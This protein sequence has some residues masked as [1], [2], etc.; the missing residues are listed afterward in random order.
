MN[1]LHRILTT[2][3]LAVCFIAAMA[4]QVSVT[5][6]PKRTVL[7]PQVM[8][9]ISNPGQYFNI[10]VQNPENEAQAIFFG[11]ELRQL[12]PTNAINIVI[13]ALTLPKQGIVIPAMQTRMLDAVQMR[14][15][16]QH[17]R[18]SDIKMPQGLFD[19]VANGSF[20]MLE[21]GTY[22]IVLNAYKWDPTLSSPVLLSN[23]TLSRCTFTICY[24]ASAPK[25]VS[26]VA[27]NDYE[28][29]NIATLSQQ[30]PM[31]QWTSPV[32]NCNPTPIT[33]TYDL[34]VVQ[35][36]PLQAPDEAMD[37]NPVV[38]QKS[39]LTMPQ[40][41][42]P[43][44]V[45][46]GFSPAAT[47]VAQITTR[48]NNTQEGTLDYVNL[49]NNG[50]SDLLMFRVKDNMEKPKPSTDTT[51]IDTSKT[52]KGDSIDIKGKGKNSKDSLYVFRNPELTEPSFTIGDGARKIFLGSD[53]VVKWR[54]PWKSGGY[55]AK[56][57]SIKFRYDVEFYVSSDYQ[58]RKKIL[59][60]KPAFK[61]TN[62]R[63]TTDTLRWS[64]IEEKVKNGDYG[65]VRIVPKAVNEKSVRFVNDSINTIDFALKD[66]LSPSFEC[67]NGLELPSNKKPT[68]LKADEL[69][70]KTVKIGE[71]DLVLDGAILKA[72]KE[73]GHFSGTGHVIWQPLRS[74]WNLAVKFDD[75]AINTDNEVFFGLVET[76]EGDKG[77]KIEGS[78][79][80][81]S[82]FSNWGIDNPMSDSSIPY[83]DKIEQ[84]NDDGKAASLA[85]NLGSKIISYYKLITSGAA[86]VSGL[87]NGDIKD[88]RFPLE[89][90]DEINPTPV[91]IQI[92]KMKFAPTY[93][94]MDFFG[95]YV[96]PE[97][98][99]TKNQILIFGAPRICISPKSLVPEG[100]TISLLKNFT[101]KDPATSYDCTF[102]AP[103]NLITPVD[104]CYVSWSD[105]KFEALK[106]DIDM[107]LPNLKKVENG[108]A[109]NNNPK[110]HVTA[111]VKAPINKDGE[112]LAGWD[113]FGEASLDPFEHE[114]L[115][116]YTFHAADKVII[117][118]SMRENVQGMSKFPKDYDM[119]KAELD[120]SNIKEWMGVF[121]REISMEFPK[122]IKI[123][124]GKE[125]MKVA[126]SN[127]FIDKSGMTV[128]AG[129]VNAINYKHGENGTIGG[130]AFSMDTIS[131]NFIQNQHR[132]FRIC[133]SMQIP[134]LKGTV[135]YACNIYN[136]R[137]TGKGTKEGYA[138]VFKTYQMEDLSLNFLLGDLTLDEKLTY[139]LVEALPDEQGELQTNVE[140]LLGGKV[141]IA[142]TKT[143][144]KYIKEKTK[145]LPLDLTLPEIKFCKMRVA[146]NKSFESVY[147]RDLQKMAIKEADKK[148][149]DRGRTIH[150]WN[151]AKDLELVDGKLFLNL[152]QWGYASPQKKIGPF[153]FTI[154]KCKGS[155]SGKNLSLALGGTLKFCKELS[156]EAG[157]GIK[158]N[159]ELVIPKDML[160][161]SGYSLEYKGI[162]FDSAAISFNMTGLAMEGKLR[163]VNNDKEGGGYMGTLK[164]NVGD[165][166]F[167]LEAIGGYFDYKSSEKN[168][169]YGFFKAKVGGSKLGVPMGPI[170]L[171]GLTGGIYIN[172]VYNPKNEEKP[173]VSADTEG[174]IGIL[175]GVGL[176][177]VNKNTFGGD[178][179]FAV[180]V[181]P[182]GDNT[183]R[184]STFKLD[185]EMKCL[186]GA[187][188]SNVSIVYQ[189]DAKDKY[190]QLLATVD[191]K[192]DAAVPDELKGLS[193]DVEEA[194]GNLEKLSNGFKEK[195][196]EKANNLLN[197]GKDNATD[198]FKDAMSDKNKNKTGKSEKDAAEELKKETEG[199][200][201]K[202][203]VNYGGPTMNL[204]LDI[205][206]QSKK[207]GKECSPVAWHVYFGEPDVK[208]RCSFTLVDFKSKFVTVIVGANAYLCVGSE[209]PGDGQLP[210]LP[211]EVQEFLDGA[212]H[213]NAK[214]DNLSKALSAQQR[215]LRDIQANQKVDGGVMLGAQVYGKL[216]VDLG[217]FY[218]DMGATA[219]FDVSIVKLSGNAQCVNL[220]GTPG[221]KGWYGS[222]Q[223]YAYLYAK[224]GFRVMLGFFNTNIDLMH[225][226]IGGVLEAWM[227]NPNYFRGKCRAELKLL[228]GLVHINKTFQ[229]TCGDY[230]QTFLG[231]ALDEYKMFGDINIGYD[232]AAEA[233][234]KPYSAVLSNKPQIT[235]SNT[236][237]RSIRVLD[238]T[239]EDRIKN[240][241]GGEGAEEFG[242]LASRTFRF[243]LTDS[244]QPYMQEFDD[245]MAIHKGVEPKRQ[246]LNYT[247]SSE[248][249]ILNLTRLNPGKIY[250]ITM[251]GCA[252]EFRTGR[253]TDPENWD[254]IKGHYRPVPWHQKKHYYIATRP[255][256]EVDYVADYDS[257]T[258][259]VDLQQFVKLAYPMAYDDESKKKGMVILK[260]GK[261]TNVNPADLHRP[262]I[263]LSEDISGK[264]FNKGDLVWKLY[265]EN[266]TLI[267]SVPNKWITG[268]GL[269]MMTPARAFSMEPVN[270][271]AYTLR[272]DYQ[273]TTRD[274]VEGWT[275]LKSST[276]YGLAAAQQTANQWNQ[277][278]NNSKLF[279]V[280]TKQDLSGKTLRRS[281]STLT[282]SSSSTTDDQKYIVTVEKYGPQVNVR[283]YI[284]TLV[285][286]SAKVVDD[287]SQVKYDYAFKATRLD[288]VYPDYNAGS[289][290]EGFTFPEV[291][292]EELFGYSQTSNTLSGFRKYQSRPWITIDPFAYLSY[293]ANLN[294]VSGYRMKTSSY[295]LDITTTGSLAAQTPFDETFWE[296]GQSE[297]QKYNEY[298][299]EMGYNSNVNRL[300]LANS[301]YENEQTAY[302]LRLGDSRVGEGVGVRKWVPRNA[303]EI[304]TMFN[305]LTSVAEQLGDDLNTTL[306]ERENT[307]WENKK[308]WKPWLET[309][310]DK[311][312]IF[313]AGTDES[314]TYTLRVPYYQYAIVRM[315]GWNQSDD[316]VKTSEGNSGYDD[317]LNKDEVRHWR[318]Y[319]DKA[320]RAFYLSSAWSWNGQTRDRFGLDLYSCDGS[321]DPKEF[322]KSNLK[323]YS[324]Q[325]EFFWRPNDK[326]NKLYLY[327][328][329]QKNDGT[330]GDW[331]K[332]KELSTKGLGTI[333][334]DK[335]AEINEE[336]TAQ[337]TFVTEYKVEFE[338]HAFRLY[339]GV[340]DKNNGN[341]RNTLQ[342]G[343]LYKAQFTSSVNKS[344][345]KM[346]CTDYR[347]NAWD[348]NNQCWTVYGGEEAEEANSKFYIV[349]NYTHDGKRE[350]LSNGLGNTG[351]G[352]NIASGSNAASGG[353]V[354]THGNTGSSAS[355]NT[356]TL[357]ASVSK[358]SFSANKDGKQKK[359]FTVSGTNLKGLIRITVNDEAFSVDKTTLQHTNH[360]ASGTITVT[361]NAYK[362]GTFNNAVRIESAGADPVYV[363]LTAT[364][365]RSI[366]P[367]KTSIDFGSVRLNEQITE[368]IT[369][370]RMNL[371]ENIKVTSDNPFF[372][373]HDDDLNKKNYSSTLKVHFKPM[374]G[375][376][377][378][379]TLTLKSEDVT[380]TITL[381][382]T[383][384]TPKINVK[385][386]S[387]TFESTKNKEVSKMTVVDATNIGY[388]QGIT[389]KAYGEGFSV[390]NGKIDNDDNGRVMP[391]TF[392]VK[393]KPKGMGTYEG[394]VK[395][396]SLGADTVTIKLEGTCP[397]NFE[398]S[399]TS[400]DFG[401]VRVL[402]TVGKKVT[403]KC[404]GLKENIK[405][406]ID[407]QAEHFSLIDNK[408]QKKITELGKDNNQTS[409]YVLYVPQTG[410]THTATLK[411]TSGDLTKTIKLTGAAKE[412]RINVNKTELTFQ[413]R[414]N[415][416]TQQQV[417]VNAENIGYNQGIKVDV[418]GTAFS[419]DKKID[420]DDNGAVKNKTLTVKFKPAGMGTYNE[421]LT[422]SSQGAATQTIKLTGTCP[423]DF[424]PSVSAIDFGSVRVLEPKKR[425]VTVK[426][427]GLAEKIQLAV[428]GDVD[429]F[430]LSETALDKD[431]S[432]GSFWVTYKPQAGG[433]H[434]ITI[435]LISG[436][437]Q[438]TV[439]VLG[440]AK[441]PSISVNRSSLV[442]SGTKDKEIKQNIT[443]NG[444][445]IGYNQG[446]KVTVQ[447]R[448]YSLSTNKLDNDDRGTVSNKTLTVKFKPSGM[449]D[450][451][452][453]IILSSQGAITQTIK[454]TGTCAG[455][456]EPTVTTLAFGSQRLLQPVEK[457]ISV[458]RYGLG[459]EIKVSATG[460]TRH[461]TIGATALRKDISEG[462]FAVT[463]KPLSGGNH[464][465]TI[466]LT[467]GSMTKTVTVTGTG[468]QPL[469]NPSTT[470]LSFSAKKNQTQQKVINVN[471]YNIG[472]NQNVKV[473][474]SGKGYTIK[475]EVL[476]H[477]NGRVSNKTITVSFKPSG[478]GDY[479]GKVTLSTQGG[480]TKT[481]TL[482]GTCP[483]S[484][485]PSVTSLDFGQERLAKKVTREITVNYEDLAEDI[486]ISMS[487]PYN[488]FSLS[489]TKLSKDKKRGT[490]KVYFIPS[491]VGT[492]SIDILLTSGNLTK[493][494]KVSGRGAQPTLSVTGSSRS[495]EANK[496]KE[497]KTYI[498]VNATN[499]PNEHGVQASI[500][501]EGFSLSSNKITGD[502]NGKVSNK[503][504]TVKF[505]S[506]KKGD[507]EGTLKIAVLT[508]PG[509]FIEKTVTLKVK[510]K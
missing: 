36:M 258:G 473:S 16:F 293:M 138:Y 388:N 187:I 86:K 74:V 379:A 403:V 136:Q 242:A 421:S 484:I 310:K 429:H 406:S 459:E 41:L 296:M 83:A 392:N 507:Y 166:L 420:N 94:T 333:D 435:T 232:N 483:G 134:L 2:F 25:W 302:P 468:L 263:S 481:I 441:V 31:L 417:I 248:Q 288:A 34:K 96:V 50:K 164:V 380:R 105:S 256:G 437:L 306:T 115:P 491:Y 37:R 445:N 374:A 349:Y 463:Y 62:V 360:K 472:Y 260:S 93:A 218:A 287:T 443:V 488:N 60:N 458:K 117:D 268:D 395:F 477:D 151:E 335:L 154:T 389:V 299:I 264:Y 17:V 424:E 231:N 494:I 355:A 106:I 465:I 419:T 209:L 153:E 502:D 469:I 160:D 104:G 234:E 383:G 366:T 229:F 193:K 163:V 351:S 503:S 434:R 446:I 368:E 286:L 486:R 137:V 72:G 170:S 485:T 261:S 361:F 139:M 324:D 399:V 82:L 128:E 176:A 120:G 208:K 239:E 320:A 386:K 266:K 271:S 1:T 358:L 143:A 244:I 331:K 204:S 416:E 470:S 42:I 118:H 19:N 272:L 432:N 224:L 210:P 313:T 359:S 456:F 215:T 376:E 174:A 66:V 495:F 318:F 43:V 95:T 97:T 228:G 24:Q 205:R 269:C 185:G 461:F 77:T 131:V 338:C 422:L 475:P 350:I 70:G 508:A 206:I 390:E 397:G 353:N 279:R 283:L 32:V 375:G 119:K 44:N 471:A 173:Q 125:R 56:P 449:G 107:T 213:G 27:T 202:K 29:R 116:G 504:F 371:N 238:P 55:G 200:K 498:Y 309:H 192:S 291:T 427:E 113:W 249:V 217:L 46:K 425:E 196:K 61:L 382:G 482:D 316:N 195:M 30:V 57:D 18:Q 352:G 22:E 168:F 295:G 259:A 109:T 40:C 155:F 305:N 290:T 252:Q 439:T 364:C 301:R 91:N 135:K 169:S 26:P 345:K 448:G 54:K 357:T 5:I 348:I 273:L 317:D 12:T 132:D 102:K 454:L 188:T 328:R 80:V 505:K 415:K 428:I 114:D 265:D 84:K 63:E 179:E 159:S 245:T 378:K 391:R 201:T 336:Y 39:S 111:D 150:W 20:G 300:F 148:K 499:V 344:L 492:K 142:G 99:V 343:N 292:D 241:S 126:L 289:G 312:A 222:G 387:F 212:V 367:S 235:T 246:Y 233:L 85:D 365:D 393:F 167:K 144:N 6:T 294:F 369:V 377:Q 89:I 321:E 254:S 490:F 407:G 15:L 33:Y 140:L 442:F 197:G 405:L 108:K 101:I 172:C 404:E 384:K 451:P 171:T 225:A 297:G 307:G 59:A 487:N 48:S 398:P 330:W 191:A 479:P 460:D 304:V 262:M 11:A 10:S 396:Y 339:A 274:S 4:E 363:D 152:G 337:N 3:T 110:L 92:S 462:S 356:P 347:I 436:D 332:S 323:N 9:Y 327:K 447:G 75:I 329:E 474:V 7:P 23:P 322:A 440:S 214:S 275:T 253:W 489:T 281:T 184:L 426:R 78:E 418:T 13:P 121:I 146:N 190:F 221:Y 178:F 127:M 226:G 141:T 284:D 250:R 130:F 467:S 247:I 216:K 334:E 240:T 79:L 409:F 370:R 51:K 186:G 431:R 341:F 410:N 314:N 81:D 413:G 412:P 402:K 340:K 165:D 38:Y 414:K 255:A 430:Q 423:G 372:T 236:L 28:G 21:E 315:G 453:T 464:R 100:T 230:C 466:S 207:N 282:K 52:A 145:G 438:K 326:A 73:P 157:A 149:D 47:Y 219:G 180:C 496:G 45:I 373:V 450:Y 342:N 276:V 506:N 411:L 87:L 181:M 227:P 346:K 220:G 308:D 177:T 277:Q 476:N 53:I 183:Y 408:V 278:F 319:K 90:P 129:I 500:T 385:A 280:S 103:K 509:E 123:G 69:K 58:D 298:Q 362:G 189:N 394:S 400:L 133:G 203:E 158:I 122:D 65:L 237:D 112:K 452:G 49:Q 8:L 444:R 401:T 270:Q 457:K 199:D 478:M 175:F 497:A 67:S 223:L 211:S 124:N 510:C 354:G 285:N 162:D 198:S 325:S 455:G 88:V 194:K 68:T 381:S 156:I 501:G 14:S 433:D 480:V 71:Y 76:F 147:E 303:K 35:M 311:Y 493:K 161:L 243:H 257:I 64:A 98:Q 267:D 182:N 251:A